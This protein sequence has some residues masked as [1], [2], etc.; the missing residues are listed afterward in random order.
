M[1]PIAVSENVDWHFNQYYNSRNKIN[2]SGN[3]R[4]N[5]EISIVK[6]IADRSRNDGNGK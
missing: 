4:N 2:H 1:F 6:N 5:I 3:K